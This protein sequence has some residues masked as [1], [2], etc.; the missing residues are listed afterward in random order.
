MSRE[1]SI[2]QAGLVPLKYWGTTSI[3]SLDNMA[4]LDNRDN[5]VSIEVL[6]PVRQKGGDSDGLF[7]HQKQ[8]SVFY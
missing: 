4:S 1:V 3:E 5:L 7:I 8:H 2:K 6:I